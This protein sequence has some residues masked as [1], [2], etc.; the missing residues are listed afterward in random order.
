MAAH[1]PPGVYVPVPTF[2]AS[3]KAADYDPVAAPVDI[4]TQ[5]A[6]SLYGKHRAPSTHYPPSHI[7]EAPSELTP[8]SPQDL[9]KAGIKGLV[10]LGSTGEAI[11]LTSA[12]RTTIL[13]GVRQAYDRE[14]FPDYPIVA[15]TA[16]QNVAET[17]EQLRG[18]RDAGA[19]WGLCLVP[20][21]FAGAS[22]QEGIVRWFTAV[23][24]QSPIPIMI[25]HYPGV[26]NNVKVTVSTIVT[27]SAHA[28]IVGCKLSH[29]DVSYHAQVASNP[30]IDHAHFATFTGLGQQLLPVIAVGAAGAIDGCAGFF[31][32]TVVKLYELAL[33][34]R[35]SDDEV[36]R[37]RALQF[38]VSA[39][40]ELVVRFGTV[41]I[42]EA[43][44]RL[45]GMG[46]CDGTRLPLFG[47]IPGGDDE[48]AKWKECVGMMEEEENSL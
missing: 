13:S 34:N 15:G 32:K 12:E 7:Q 4:A 9:A 46:D 37:R 3:K 16:T 27:L 6:H 25:Y 45:R 24:D 31:P 19:Q 47:G 11:H 48:W 39:M 41:G 33:K 10:L 28:N 8:Q 30:S 20:G 35:P 1:P 21:Y 26:S 23:A 14:G 17:V 43:V 38:K 36:A 5:V 40:E 42:K 29:G 18:A 22:T 44:S 2:F